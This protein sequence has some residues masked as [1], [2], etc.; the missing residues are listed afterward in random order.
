[1]T[2]DEA[3]R[4]Q[5]QEAQRKA[6]ESRRAAKMARELE[7]ELTRREEER[8]KQEG[9]PQITAVDEVNA[10]RVL[11]KNLSSNDERIA[12]QA[13]TKIL[14]YAKGR[15]GVQQEEQRDAKIILETSFVPP[16]EIATT[17]DPE[18]EPPPPTVN[19]TDD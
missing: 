9:D 18:L 8:Q 13:A 2:D 19:D 10:L 4:R 11:R 14:E 3:R 17:Y 16:E 5:R 6:V 1:M 7:A 12:Q 15:P